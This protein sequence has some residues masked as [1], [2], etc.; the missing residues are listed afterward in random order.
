[1]VVVASN[2]KRFQKLS[3]PPS[4]KKWK[5]EDRTGAALSSG[6]FLLFTVKISVNH[7]V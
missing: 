7:R 4:K 5:V 2:P 1:M 6:E 3:Q